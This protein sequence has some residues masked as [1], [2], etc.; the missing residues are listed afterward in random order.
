MGGNQKPKQ[1][2]VQSE[3]QQNDQYEVFKIADM[4]ID[5]LKSVLSQRN[6][7]TTG[8]RAELVQ[9]LLDNN[10]SDEIEVQVPPVMSRAN[11][12]ANV[13]AGSNVQ[14]QINEL[15]GALDNIVALLQQ[16][17]SNQ[18]VQNEP[19]RESVTTPMTTTSLQSGNGR[20][21]SIKEISETIPELYPTNPQSLTVEQFTDRVSSVVQAYQFDEKCVLLAVYSRLR[22]VAR[23][24]L[25]AQPRVHT[26]WNDF[27]NDLVAEFGVHLDEAQIHRV[28]GEN[29]RKSNERIND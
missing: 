19:S 23:M 29:V 11:S 4:K 27:S 12:N 18:N 26:S 8:S 9:R 13:S 7:A 20:K 24:W 15:R 3:M 22:G 1:N 25:D 10:G 5:Q 14:E 2:K 17:V 6:L 16:S 21:E 28:M